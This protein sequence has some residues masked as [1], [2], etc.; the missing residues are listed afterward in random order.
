MEIFTRE[1][2]RCTISGKIML[3]PVLTIEGQY[4]EY[5]ELIKKEIS[6][7]KAN[8]ISIFH[9]NFN[10]F[11]T[12]MTCQLMQD[13][14]TSYLDKNPSEKQYQYH[15]EVF[16]NDIFY[17][18][19]HVTRQNINRP[20]KHLFLEAIN[21]FCSFRKFTLIIINNT[22]NLVKFLE[23]LDVIKH[24]AICNY[25]EINIRFQ[26]QDISMR[27]YYDNYQI[28]NYVAI[29][30]DESFTFMI[31]N[32][33][34]ELLF[35]E[36]S[37]KNTLLHVLVYRDNI[38]AMKYLIDIGM[39]INKTNDKGNTPLHLACSRNKKANVIKFLIQNGAN[40]YLIDND[41]STCFHYMA[42]Y[43]L[44][45]TIQYYLKNLDDP[46][47]LQKKNKFGMNLFDILNLKGRIDLVKEIKEKYHLDNPTKKHRT[48]ISK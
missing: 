39:D 8:N 22:S 17:F 5:F 40:P 34:K 1:D 13:T 42:Q 29:L 38:P 35:Q 41:G 3:N 30:P 33:K 44:Y 2:M 9:N 14:I 43:Q 10:D 4:V 19:I 25:N 28:Y 48:N 7:L 45:M 23:N 32:M 36:S 37:D 46:S 31:K 24:I 6:I 26:F 20:N 15:H 12:V 27:A 47:V 16:D 11:S 21:Y 18:L